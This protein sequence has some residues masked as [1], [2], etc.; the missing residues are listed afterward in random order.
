MILETR[1]LALACLVASILFAAAGQV[2]LKQG[3][4]AFGP[5][6]PSLRRPGRALLA[7]ARNV[8]LLAGIALY[9]LSAV[10]WLYGLSR[11]E[12]SYA[13]PLLALHMILV[14]LG[15]RWILK[16]PVSAFRW[17]GIGLIAVG[18]ALVASS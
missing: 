4:G 2:F 15:A 3:V 12:L 10:L 1:L 17:S 6:G 16:E 11:V 18:V 9:F 5:P 14:T 8:R 13:Y 7:A